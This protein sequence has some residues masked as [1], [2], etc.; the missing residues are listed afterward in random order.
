MFE[1]RAASLKWKLQALTFLGIAVPASVGGLVLAFGVDDRAVPIVL[2]VAGVLGIFQLVGSIASLVAKWE[3]GYAYALQSIASNHQLSDNFKELGERP[4]ATLDELKTR[5]AFLD[6]DNRHRSS[7]DYVQGLT[8]AEK[9]R[10]HRAALR[11][12]RRQCATCGIIP[13]SL[14]ATTCGTC[15]DF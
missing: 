15:G 13:E 11:Q 7:L 4:P 5:A 6:A 2:W 8:D 3:D 12:F 1:Q 9:R 14:K 10:G